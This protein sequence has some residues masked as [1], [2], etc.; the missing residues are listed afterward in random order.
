MR[1]L[2]PEKV[3]TIINRLQDEGYEAYAVGGCIR[4]SYLGR[5]PN[6]WDITTSAT[7]LQVKSLFRRTVDIGIEHG[8]V[9]VMDGNDGFE[10]TTYR[11]DGEYEDS[12]HP[13]DVTFTGSLEEDLKRRDF[14]MNAMAYNDADGLVDLFGGIEDMQRGLVRAV[15]NPEERFAED[16]LRILRAMRFSAQLGYEV[17][18]N[19]EQAIR[20]LA[21]TL[22]KI[23]AERIREEFEK[24]IMSEHP[25]KLRELYELGITR[26]IFPE[27]D[28]MMECEQNT[29]YHYL[30]V[31]EHTICG[32]K[33][34]VDNPGNLTDE[35]ARLV[36][37]AF[38]LHDVGK[39]CCKTVDESGVAHFKKHPE[40]GALIAEEILK[41][42]KYDNATINE[43]KNLVRYHDERPVLE[44][45]YVRRL[46]SKLGAGRA[47]MLMEIK[48]KDLYAHSDY[49]FDELYHQ[50]VKLEQLIFE[51]LADKDALSVHELALSGKSLICMGVK[52]G[53]SM[54]RIL[55]ELLEAVLDNP[56]LNTQEG[57]TKLLQS[58]GVI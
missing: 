24:L 43:V 40:E 2:L 11:I 20:K 41:R 29:P 16:A 51:I 4:D 50:L 8:T 7:P 27:W 23:S 32:L 55:D 6:D 48:W 49:R 28:A 57:L 35:E 26:V 53:P 14:T 39:P 12:R 1:I 22:S 33:K 44:K 15:G 9:K 30:N 17:E 54:G 25:E 5:V 21:S 19:T 47:Q 45:K 18:A 42:L 56:T 38:V 13:K 31:G 46:L 58:K 34:L 52:P 10:V 3:R 36:R 37:I